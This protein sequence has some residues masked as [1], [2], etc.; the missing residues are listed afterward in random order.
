MR[1]AGTTNKGLAKR[2]ADFSSADG[3]EPIAPTH[4]NVEKWLSG[5]TRRPKARTCHVLVKVLSGA[6]GRPVTVDEV[7]YG[8]VPAEGVDSTLEYPETASDSINTLKPD[9]ARNA[10][11]FLLAEVA[12]N[13]AG[14]VRTRLL[15][16]CRAI[17]GD[18]SALSTSELL[19]HLNADTEAPGS[20]RAGPSAPGPTSDCG[21]GRDAW[22]GRRRLA[23]SA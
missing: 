14:S 2:M 13:D 6:L 11:E 9:R 18:Q 21:T 22:F 4:T 7:G 15:A 10:A 3:G 12:T 17:F 8:E 16:D 20:C 5:E 19:R 1:E 23:T